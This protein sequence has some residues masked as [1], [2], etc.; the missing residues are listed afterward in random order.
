MSESHQLYLTLKSWAYT[1]SIVFCLLHVLLPS[2]GLFYD[3]F[4]H[5]HDAFQLCPCRSLPSLLLYSQPDV[6]VLCLGLCMSPVEFH[7]GPLQVQETLPEAALTKQSP[8]LSIS[9]RVGVAS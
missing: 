6:R 9:L 5:V 4:I 7:W 8:P 3:I 2:K 1:D